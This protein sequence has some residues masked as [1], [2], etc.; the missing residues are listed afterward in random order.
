LFSGEPLFVYLPD[1]NKTF[2]QNPEPIELFPVRKHLGNL[3]F[4]SFFYSWQWNYLHLSWN[5]IVIWR[6][7]ESN[8]HLL[9]VA[10]A[11]G[12]NA[13]HLHHMNELM[14]LEAPNDQQHNQKIGEPN[15][16]SIESIVSSTSYLKCRKEARVCIL[17][18]EL[19]WWRRRRWRAVS[20]F[21]M[22]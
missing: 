10:E 9:Y 22:T 8:E 13:Q 16:M 19:T 15:L 17:W 14:N 6:L 11:A 20:A 18:P 7:A 1:N 12:L 4:L 21:N 2:F 5:K 3:I